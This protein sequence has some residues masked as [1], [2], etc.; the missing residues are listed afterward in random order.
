MPQT[1]PP[2]PKN[3][4][5]KRDKALTKPIRCRRS[6]LDFHLAAKITAAR[7]SRPATVVK[8][9]SDESNSVG[10][11]RDERT[12]RRDLGCGASRCSGAV[13][14]RA[15]SK[16]WGRIETAQGPGG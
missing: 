6:D 10:A 12:G 16:N 3:R 11:A 14:A 13:V 8:C 2:A 1:D 15:R 4:C 5:A 7:E 9:A